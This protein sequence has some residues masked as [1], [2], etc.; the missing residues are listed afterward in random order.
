M[1]QKIK[2]FLLFVFI[3]IS[4][5][6]NAVDPRLNWKTVETSHFYI[7]YAQGYERLAQKTANAAEQAHEK[8]Q[9]AI[10]WQPN[11]KTHLVVSDETDSAN[12]YATPIPFNRSVIFVAPPDSA[13]GLEDFDDWLETLIIHE[14]THVLHL[15]KAS[16]IADG[17]RSILG[18]QFLLFPNV[19]QPGWFIEGLSTFHETDDQQ[20]IGRGQSTLYKM[21]MRNEVKNGIKPANQVNLPILS[22]PTRTVSYLYGVHFYQFIQQTYGQKGIDNLI[23]NYSDNIIPFMINTNAEQVF[24]KDI[25]ALWDEFSIWL[26]KR[27][28]QEI[29]AQKAAGIVEGTKITD[30]GYGTGQLDINIQNEIFYIARGAFEHPEVMR[31]VNNQSK[32]IAEVHGNA[33]INVHSES[34]VLLT[35]NEFCDEYN[36]NSDIF[37]IEKGEDEAQQI[38]QCGHY[39]SATWSAN[40]DVIIATKLIKGRSLLVILSKSGD[41]IKTL[42]KGN[43]TD[44]VSQIKASPDGENIIAAVFRASSGWNIEE[45]NLG[46]LN[47]RPITDDRYIDMYPSYSDNGDSVL[48]SS[49]RTGRYQIYRYKKESSQI[50][51]LTRV[52]DGAF[53]PVQLNY[54]SPLF[55]DGYNSNGHDIYKIEKADVLTVMNLNKQASKPVATAPFVKTGI[56]E[57]YFALSSIYP[58]WWFPFISLNQ[59]RNE[60]G[61]TSGGNDALG[62]HNYSLNLAYDTSNE[63]LVGNINYSY[64]NRFSF[65][66]Q[67]STE[68]LRFQTGEFAIARNTDDVFMSFKVNQPGVISSVQYRFGAALS[69]T[70][71]GVRA[72]GIVGL[73]DSKDN[74][75]G[76]AAIF[77]NTHKYIRSISLADG[78]DVRLFAESSDLLESNF[79]GEIYTLDWR[80]FLNLGNQHVL[81]LRLVQGWGTQQPKPFRLGGED[82]EVAL[83]DFIGPVSESLFGKR[84]YALRGYAEGLPQLRGRRMQLASLE[85]RFPGSLVERG[86]MSPP[87]GIIQWSGSV[88]TEAG[89]AYKDS[90]A[91]QYYSSA[92]VE[93]Q[94]DIN[95]FYGI[96]SRMRLGYASGF[97]ENIGENRVYFNLGASF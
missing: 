78:R 12:G 92:G 70:K 40:G 5:T 7:H 86:L 31:R 15:D 4:N 27:Y 84:D 90:S 95:L 73:P 35:Q 79:S 93:L 1:K 23:E 46:S 53:N 97:D 26:K 20:G 52:A 49:E 75:L 57:D 24:E 91:D 58:R 61:F 16:G 6:A 25:D 54:E 11:D 30:L 36:I 17:G 77:R 81:A 96:T 62:I 2:L 3:N 43:D 45:F 14:Y 29:D 85:W 68:I 64:A 44:I 83:L 76:V 69:Q 74:L 10:N 22:W 71:D 8:L 38:T 47:W 89:A 9:P 56:D 33:K 50:E 37:I 34:G 42:W 59:D 41:E 94:A 39:R 55:Y 82:N 18:R 72:A 80:E 63:W 21:M 87:L 60:Y 67:R 65:G 28:Q 88:F 51:Q 66:Y 13:T 19:F 32:A 48:F